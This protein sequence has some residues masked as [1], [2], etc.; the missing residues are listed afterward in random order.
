MRGHVRRRGK[1]WT[2]VVCIGREDGRPRYK[3][4]SGFETKKQ[5]ETRLTELLRE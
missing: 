2:V 3:W 1:T 5:A 4:Y